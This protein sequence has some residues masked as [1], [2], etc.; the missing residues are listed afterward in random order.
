LIQRCSEL[1]PGKEIIPLSALKGDNVPL[2]LDLVEH[3]LAEGPKLFPDDEYTDQSERTLAS[4]IVREK[5]FNLT[6]EEI[7]YGVAV[8]IDE[9]S[10]NE[11]I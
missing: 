1:L 11:K 3:G 2:V 4:E 7:P 5:I 8:T 10:E 6:R 9:F